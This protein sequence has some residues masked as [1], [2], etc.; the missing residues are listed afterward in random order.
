VAVSHDSA[1]IIFWTDLF[2]L[3]TNDHLILKLR[4]PVDNVAESTTIIPTDKAGFFAFAGAKKPANGWA[5]GSYKGV[6]R[7]ERDGKVVAE[8]EVQTEIP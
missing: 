6:M 7:V 1:A 3:Q 5:T 2:G 8:S 4:G